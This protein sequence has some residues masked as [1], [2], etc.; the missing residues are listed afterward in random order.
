MCNPTIAVTAIA[1]A[2]SYINFQQQ[3]QAQKNAYE[4]QK[5]QNEIAKKNAIQRYASEQVCTSRLQIGK[6]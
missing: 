6:S 3:K 1:G 4:A 5:R 2:S